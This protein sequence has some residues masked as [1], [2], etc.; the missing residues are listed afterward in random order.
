MRKICFAALFVTVLVSVGW[1]D[2]LDT[3]VF[4]GTMLPGNEVPAAAVDA[5]SSLATITVRVTRDV[6]GNVN[7]AT[8]MF[9]IGYTVAVATSF[10]G[11]HIH[12]APAGVNGPVVI[13][14]GISG[15]TAV[16]AAAGSGRIFRTV[17]YGSTDT[18]GL[19]FVT[20]LLAAPENYYANIHSTT[21]PG[22]LMRAQ[23][24]RTSAIFRPP[25]SPL[26]EN[27]ALSTLDAE[28]AALIEVRVN[29]DAAGAINSGAVTFDVD[30]RFGSAVTITGMHIHQAVAGQ[31]GAVVIDSGINGS[32][33]AI[34]G[35]TR[36]NI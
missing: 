5:T 9:D 27:P 26:Q 31:N 21:F 8:V 30:Y 35:A 19:K 12:N 6:A 29:R 7:A 1:A 22:G 4:K 33:R 36:G 20:G 10:T 24:Q 17:N 3:A 28:G 15:T 18:D 23:L 16:S 13:N 11:L 25:L 32:S 34:S 2:T 14:T